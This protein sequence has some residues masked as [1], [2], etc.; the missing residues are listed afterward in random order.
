M[1]RDSDDYLSALLIEG[2]PAARCELVRHLPSDDFGPR[3]LGRVRDDDQPITVRGIAIADAAWVRASK[4]LQALACIHSDH[5]APLLAYGRHEGLAYFIHEHRG[6]PRLTTLLRERGGRLALDE[7]LPIF[8]QLLLAVSEAH[9]HGVV[10]GGVR[11][12]DVRVLPRGDGFHAHVRNLGLAVVLGVPAGRVGSTDHPSIYRAPE[13]DVSQSPASDVFSLGVLFVRLLTGPLPATGSDAERQQL[14]RA[15]LDQAL[16]QDPAVTDGLV[17]L[18]LEA[19][20]LDLVTRPHTATRL[21]EQLLEV[22]P[23]SA[24]RLPFVPDFTREPRPV[25]RV[26]HDVPR[27]W[28]AR[29]WTELQRWERPRERAA[30]SDSGPRVSSSRRSTLVVT[31][32]IDVPEPAPSSPAIE[33]AR[34][35]TRSPEPPRPRSTTP[36]RVNGRP[37]SMLRRVA[38]GLGLGL[39]STAGIVALV[40]AVGEPGTSAGPLPTASLVTATA[41]ADLDGREALDEPASHE[42]TV[43]VDT[44][45]PGVLTIDGKRLGPTPARATVTPGRHVMRVEARGHRTWRSRLD[46]EAGQEHRVAVA[47]VPEPEAF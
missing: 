27:R 45:P 46:L 32:P 38:A 5:A 16:E 40:V 41:E 31:P 7:L 43:V 37:R 2:P 30:A 9:L 28:P 36:D 19:V 26:D 12:Q 1:F 24:L 29:Q 13:L 23:A 25:V 35:R 18:M 15:R 44:S 39:A 10:V 6:G 11:P 33:P 14:L 20:D 34:P 42:V 3:V 8:G 47:L 4:R 21:L 22:V 17:T